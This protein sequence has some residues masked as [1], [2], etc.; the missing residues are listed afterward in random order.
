MP[1]ELINTAAAVGTFVVIAATAIAAVVQ[2][3]HLRLSNQ[4]SGLQGVFEMLRDPSVREIVNFVRHDLPEHLKDEK[5]RATL[6]HIPIDRHE[7]PEQ[8][9]CDMYNHVGSFVRSGLIDEAIYLQS[10]WFNVILYWNL[11]EEVVAIVRSN[12][13]YL[14]EN[15][16]YIAARAKLWAENHPS[17]DYPTHTARLISR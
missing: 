6:L 16:E 7:H 17:G 5:F 15:F 3:R 13:P 4:L 10:D 9:L 14:Y 8:Y 12:R 11:L 1:L 2:L